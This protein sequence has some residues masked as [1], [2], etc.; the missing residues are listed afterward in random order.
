M[1]RNF[2]LVKF[3]KI[4][5]CSA[6]TVAREKLMNIVESLEFYKNIDVYS[7]KF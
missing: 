6:T 1:F 3:P 2:Y 7:T 4:A 5:K